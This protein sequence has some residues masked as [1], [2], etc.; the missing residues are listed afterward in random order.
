MEEVI[1]YMNDHQ[2]LF[3]ILFGCIIFAI[4]VIFLSMAFA[5]KKE[6]EK[7]KEKKIE[8]ESPLEK[9][10]SL[11]QEVK[12]ENFE[13]IKIDVPSDLDQV[14]NQMEEDLKKEE[15]KKPVDYETFQ[16][17]NAIISYKELLKA[18]M[19]VKEEDE[20]NIP[21]IMSVHELEKLK[22]QTPDVSFE[23]TKK[24]KNTD[25]I[26]PIY[27][28]IN[29]NLSYPKIPSFDKATEFK[30]VEP[31]LEKKEEIEKPKGSLFVEELR[32]EMQKKEEFLEALKEFRKNL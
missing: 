2:I 15:E 25:F 10:E 7:E 1:A 27:G 19:R 28:K 9:L 31:V 12:Q 8:P 23:D 4:I 29:S 24:F 32:E 5:P 30:E 20:E 13:E 6:K 22:N 26:S 11:E 17:E 16:E 14:L 3:F 18:S 21:V